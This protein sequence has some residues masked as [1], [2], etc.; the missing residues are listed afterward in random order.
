M[1]ARLVAE[2]PSPAPRH[3]FTHALVRDTLYGDL[4][5]ARRVA[6]HRQVAEAIE[7]LHG[8][9]DDHLPAL[10]YHWGRGA[11]SATETTRAVHYASR[12]GDRALTQLAPDEAAAY[13]TSALGL[14]NGAGGADADDPRRLEPLISLGEAQRR[15]G[16]ARYRQTLLD[17]AQLARKLGDANA[18][19]RAALANT[20][21]DIYSAALVVD[22]ERVTVLEAALAAVAEGDLAIRARLLANLGMEL[23]WEPDP[24]RRVAFSDQ[25]VHLARSLEDPDTLAHVLLARDYAITGPENAAER[26]AATTEVL[27]MA[28]RLEDPVLTSRALILRFKAAMELADVAEAE[29]CLARNQELVPDLGQATLTWAAMHHDATL[30]V[31]HGDAG[32]EGAIRAAH[33]FGLASGW[34]DIVYFSGGQLVSLYL[35]QGRLGEVEQLLRQLTERTDYP[36]V[37]GMYAFILSET[38]RMEGAAGLFDELALTG[39]AHPTNT[40][41]WLRFAADCA[42]LASRLGRTDCA[43]ELRS[44]LA[45]YADQ[46]V[47]ISLGGV[48][49]GSVAFYLAVLATIMLDWPEA[50]ASFAAAAATHERIGAPTWL[51]RTRLEWARM[52]LTR[53]EPGDGDRAHELLWQALATAQELGLSSVERDAASLLPAA[54]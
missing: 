16:D 1:A 22:A 17:A 54:T 44:R 4:S 21:G 43:P 25:A 49:S 24:G 2:V 10:A 38:G 18:L 3:R 6:I 7:T 9:V 41:A 42:W 40:V 30:R 14:L 52:L 35:D 48:V 51:A 32:A 12:A 5:A 26:F 11:G 15:A 8:A 34:P 20:R 23:A 45:P 29:R 19:A 50:D 39:F 31:L 28:E 37:K 33:E 47:V 46:L 36:M 13:Y 27:A 53:A